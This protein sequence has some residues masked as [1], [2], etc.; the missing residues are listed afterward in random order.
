MSINELILCLDLFNLY[1]NKGIV[2][3]II[4]YGLDMQLNAIIKKKEGTDFE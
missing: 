1:A 3:N 4:K 2:E